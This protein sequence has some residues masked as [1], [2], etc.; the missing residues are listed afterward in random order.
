MVLCPS[1]IGYMVVSIEFSNRFI[2]LLSTF[3]MHAA[4]CCDILSDSCIQAN[5]VTKQVPIPPT[6]RSF[7]LLFGKPESRKFYFVQ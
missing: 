6:E 7:V 5:I 1:N 3:R 4:F 2:K